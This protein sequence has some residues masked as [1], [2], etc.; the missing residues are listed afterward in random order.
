MGVTLTGADGGDA[1]SAGF[2]IS[3]SGSTVLAYSLTGSTIDANGSVGCMDSAACNYDADATIEDD[4]YYEVD[5]AGECGGSAEVDECGE[6]GGNGIDEGT[7]DCECG[8][9]AEVDEC[10]ICEGDGSQCTIFL[11]LSIDESSGN[12]LVNM[13]N[14]MDVAGFQFYLTNTQINTVSGGTAEENGFMVSGGNGTVIG[15]SLSGNVIP[16]GDATLVEVDFTALWDEACLTDVVLSDPVGA[17]IN[18]EV[19]DCLPLN[20]TIVDG[21][22]DA[23]ACNFNQ[24]ANQDDGSCFYSE[25]NYDCDGNC[26]YEIDCEGVCGGSSVVDECGVCVTVMDWAVIILRQHSALEI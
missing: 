18:F 20:F 25:E 5:C 17:G 1:E 16:A 11:D 7:C 2:T 23:D 19:G 3:S 15:F 24:D 6:C 14:A 12:M 9:T 10:G 22:M 4:C 8:G 26:L 21:C 13:A